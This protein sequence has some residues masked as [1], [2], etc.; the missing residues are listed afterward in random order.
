VS[1]PKRIKPAQAER[2]QAALS[3]LTTITIEHFHR[4]FEFIQYSAHTYDE[5]ATAVAQSLERELKDEMENNVFDAITLYSACLQTR[6]TADTIRRV[7]TSCAS[8][9]QTLWKIHQSLLRLISGPWVPS[10]ATIFL[11]ECLESMTTPVPSSLVLTDSTTFNT[12]L[13]MEGPVILGIP[14]IYFGSPLSWPSIAHE[15][16]HNIL[17]KRKFLPKGSETFADW[18]YEHASDYLATRMLGPPFVAAWVESVILRKFVFADMVTHPCSM[19]RFKFIT[20]NMPQH[21]VDD[22]VID[23]CTRLFKCLE[24]ATKDP[25]KKLARELIPTHVDQ[26]L[27]CGQILPRVLE[28]AGSQAEYNRVVDSLQKDLADVPVK[29]Y[30]YDIQVVEHLSD[31]LEDG[32]P[33]SAVTETDP[34]LNRLVGSLRKAS[35]SDRAARF[36]TIAKQLVQRPARASHIMHA[37]WRFKL[38]HLSGKLE[39][40]LAGFEES[41]KWQFFEE[42]REEIKSVDEFIVASIATSRFHHSLEGLN[43]T[44]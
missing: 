18:A 19:R 39:K 3:F 40:N 27:S 31:Q 25:E 21:W 17:T 14:K 4:F 30:D 15:L 43:A 2:P 16:A 5:G 44:F 22:P 7:V 9:I 11:A 41:R 26:C 37:G 12:E 32:I 13:P 8:A 10:A 28:S 35:K 23:H 34:S 24:A 38:S 36:N 33:A 29:E 6:F 42:M 20:T 1:P